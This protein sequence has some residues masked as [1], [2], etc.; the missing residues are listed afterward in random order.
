[1]SPTPGSISDPL[2]LGWSTLLALSKLHFRSKDELKCVTTCRNA[3]PTKHSPIDTK[4]KCHKCHRSTA[5][6]Q[7]QSL[8]PL[9]ARQGRSPVDVADW[10]LETTTSINSHPAS[11]W[12]AC[13]KP[14][15][16]AITTLVLLILICRYLTLKDHQSLAVM[17]CW[18]RIHYY[19]ERADV[20]VDIFMRCVL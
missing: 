19:L 6:C 4:T 14:C 3:T 2:R 16:S 18:A 10:D 5:I 20:Q 8:V 9:T 1:M 12:I 17:L 15:V 7:S 11:E 13:C